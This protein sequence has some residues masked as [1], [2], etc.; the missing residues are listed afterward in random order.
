M[1]LC[2]RVRACVCVCGLGFSHSLSQRQCRIFF[3][4]ARKHRKIRTFPKLQRFKK[5]KT[6]YSS[7]CTDDGSGQ[8][9]V[10]CHQSV[11]RLHLLGPKS[12][13]TAECLRNV[14]LPNMGFV[15]NMRRTVS[16]KGRMVS[17]KGGAVAGSTRNWRRPL[18]GVEGHRRV[19]DAP[20]AW[21]TPGPSHQC[22]APGDW[23]TPRP[24]A[25]HQRLVFYTS[26][27]S[28][29]AL[30]ERVCVVYWYSFS[31]PQSSTFIALGT[32]AGPRA[33]RPATCRL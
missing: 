9:R 19:L 20:L 33:T 12:S 23:P 13:G 32:P 15:R 29:V 26:Q 28:A 17:E 8:E 31:N 21:L 11:Q 1:C 3:T 27:C 18:G 2:V 4:L 14:N 10:G 6:V 5:F 24:P 7:Y 30:G 22:H 25:P 16:E